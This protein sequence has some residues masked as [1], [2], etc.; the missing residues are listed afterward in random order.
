MDVQLALEA[1]GMS[2]Q[3]AVQQMLR[4]AAAAG[5]QRIW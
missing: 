3:S 5:R 2:A 1:K 4:D